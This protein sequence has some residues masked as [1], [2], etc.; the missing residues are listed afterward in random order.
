MIQGDLGVPVKLHG[1]EKQIR[2]AEESEITLQKEKQERWGR[3]RDHRDPKH[4]KNSNPMA[5]HFE[6]KEARSQVMQEAPT[7]WV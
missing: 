6:V 5:T 3:S 7:S 1:P 4:W 2:K